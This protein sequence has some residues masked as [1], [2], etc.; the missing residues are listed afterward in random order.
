MKQSLA[1]LAVVALLLAIPAIAQ[2]VGP[3]RK[4]QPAKRVSMVPVNADAQSLLLRSTHI[5]LIRIESANVG[6]WVA[7]E[8][9]PT[10]RNLE[11]HL[12]IEEVLK[13]TLVTG[14]PKPVTVKARQTR[15]VGTR[16]YAVPGVWSEHDVGAGTRLVAF[17]ISAHNAGEEVL[18]EGRLQTLL[19]PEESIADARLF[20]EVESKKLRLVEVLEQANRQAATL[21]FLFADYIGDCVE[22]SEKLGAPE[23]DAIRIHLEQPK[24]APEARSTLVGSINSLLTTAD[25]VPAAVLER[26]VTTLFHQIAIPASPDAD[27]IIK[28]YIPNLVGLSGGIKRKTAKAVF[29]EQPRERGKAEQILRDYK[30][31][32][33]A[34]KLQAWLGE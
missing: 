1:E 11:L 33:P 5:L 24:L 31:P 14:T 22:T 9:G 26:W 28:V 12:I 7:E 20:R 10:R 18:S 4:Q 30:G 29:T 27:N 17:S 16:Y 6:P 3:P 23:L 25:P 15:R 34:E 8:E 19:P 13:G 21:G 2:R 32:A